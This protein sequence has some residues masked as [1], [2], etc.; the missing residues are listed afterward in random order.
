MVDTERRL[1]L[2]LLC[3]LEISG[4]GADNGAL[5]K[6]HTE[7]QTGTVDIRNAGDPLEDLQ[8]QLGAI[9]SC[10][11]QPLARAKGTRP[12]HVLQKECEECRYRKCLFLRGRSKRQDQDLRTL[13]TSQLT[14]A[15]TMYSLSG[16]TD[17]SLS[18][19]Y[20]WAPWGCRSGAGG[21]PDVSGYARFLIVN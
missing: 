17:I 20:R 16:S 10:C 12:L 14:L 8:A 3:P 1:L 7:N 9:Y 18:A 6:E 19:P 4:C 13:Q 11:R 15:W 21:L 5:P 2:P